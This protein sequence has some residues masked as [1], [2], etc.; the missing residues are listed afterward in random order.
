MYSLPQLS[1]EAT[2]G[3]SRFH[4]AYPVQARSYLQ[5][6]GGLTML[7]WLRTWPSLLGNLSASC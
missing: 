3:P 4:G 1:G 7:I 6:P 5:W 2:S